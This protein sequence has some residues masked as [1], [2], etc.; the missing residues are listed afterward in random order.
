MVEDTGPGIADEYLDRIFDA[1]FTTKEGSEGLGLG[2]T[3]SN[4]IIEELDGRWR[5]VAA[6]GRGAF[7]DSAGRPMQ[8]SRTANRRFLIVVLN[9]SAGDASITSCPTQ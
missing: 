8:T 4:R 6:V 9:V 1:F 5:P 2:L 7:H 3:I